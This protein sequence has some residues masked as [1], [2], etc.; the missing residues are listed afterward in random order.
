MSIINTQTE[1]SAMAN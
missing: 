1:K